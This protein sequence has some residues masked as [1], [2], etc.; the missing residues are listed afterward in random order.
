MLGY[1]FDRLT[2][3]RALHDDILAR[4]DEVLTFARTFRDQNKARPFQALKLD[5]YQFSLMEAVLFAERGIRSFKAL[6][7]NKN[8]PIPLA[9]F[10]QVFNFSQNISAALNELLPIVRAMKADTRDFVGISGSRLQV[11][12]TGEVPWDIADVTQRI[13]S[14]TDQMMTGVA[15]IA[16]V[17]GA[18]L[19]AG[20]D[21]AAGIVRDEVGEVVSALAQVDAATKEAQSLLHQVQAA[22]ARADELRAAM[23]AKLAEAT[24]NADDEI[25]SLSGTV[26]SVS[27]SATK[28]SS[29]AAVAASKREE[30]DR[31]AARVQEAHKDIEGFQASL[32]TTR[33]RL[34]DAQDKAIALAGE[35]EGQRAK[36]ADMIAQAERMV[37][38]STVAGL[39]KAFDDERKDLDKNMK[40]AFWGFML[41]IALLFVT[42]GALAAYILNIPIHGL[43]WLTKRGTADPTLAQVLSRAVIVIAPFWLTL[44]SAR[45]Y[46]SP[47]RPKKRALESGSRVARYYPS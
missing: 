9:P 1:Q 35:F 16:S 19:N 41:G 10:D 13:V 2:E 18:S 17:V 34:K 25:E 33:K 45:R 29:D 30:V 40:G 6:R 39:A 42:S 27:E 37:S 20:N 36:V 12:Q 15:T 24:V 4:L 47:Q 11:Q 26:S 21:Q 14:H 46:R 3:L 23:E 43:E 31:L 38:G 22:T 7:I 44:F 28:A 5:G 8:A 32:D